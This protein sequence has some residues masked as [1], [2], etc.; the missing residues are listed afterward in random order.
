MNCLQGEKWP[1]E[2]WA[3]E[4]TSMAGKR[5]VALMSNRDEALAWFDNLHSTSESD[6]VLLRSD[7]AFQ[8]CS[9]MR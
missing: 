1:S 2:V 5:E 8:R 4:Y 7:A 3:V 6:P 9:A